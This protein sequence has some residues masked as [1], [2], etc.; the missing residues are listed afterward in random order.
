MSLAHLHLVLNH[1]PVVGILIAGVLF[2]IAV[3]WRNSQLE[4]LTL[5]FLVAFALLTI[6]VYLTGE[7]AEHVAERLPGVAEALIERHEDAAL[8]TLVVVEVLGAGALI[9]LG[10]YRRRLLPRVFAVGLVGLV[11]ITS[12]LFAW[13]GYLGGQIRHTEIRAASPAV[14]GPVA[15]SRRHGRDD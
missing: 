8:A 10:L 9:G 3:R 13:T 12:G 5:G 2:V 15:E 4:R 1:V 11:V 6:P 7:S 14:T